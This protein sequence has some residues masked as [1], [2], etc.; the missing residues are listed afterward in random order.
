MR[1][2][3]R[4]KGKADEQLA[5]EAAEFAEEERRLQL[6]RPREDGHDGV[7]RTAAAARK[8][9][10]ERAR[11]QALGFGPGEPRPLAGSE[12]A[13]ELALLWLW[14]HEEFVS[15]L[16]RAVDEVTPAPGSR[17]WS[18]LS[19]KELDAE[20]A[21]V[22]KERVARELELERRAAE[23]RRQEAAAALAA[24]EERAAQ[25]LADGAP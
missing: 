12:S 16:H 5:A 14:Q 19:R 11:E 22:R 8:W 18:T 6:Q 3:A 25:T 2:G 7:E 15:F 17:G 4:F 24:V 10:T 1:L 23:E 20:R 21:R 13:A 9:A